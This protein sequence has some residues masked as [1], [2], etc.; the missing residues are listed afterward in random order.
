MVSGLG[1]LMGSLAVRALGQV[2]R[3]LNRAG[4]GRGC[5]WPPVW[6]LSWGAHSLCSM[7]VVGGQGCTYKMG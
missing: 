4:G 7:T 5:G 3:A 6:R 1:H 2:S